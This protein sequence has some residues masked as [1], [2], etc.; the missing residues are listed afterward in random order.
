MMRM[1]APMKAVTI[2]T[3]KAAEGRETIRPT[4]SDSVSRSAPHRADSG[5]SQRWSGPQSIRTA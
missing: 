1:G 5:S 2:A 4:T 3:G